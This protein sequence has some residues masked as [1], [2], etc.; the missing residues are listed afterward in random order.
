MP[1]IVPPKKEKEVRKKPHATVP[2]STSPTKRQVKRQT[3][4]K[5]TPDLIVDAVHYAEENPLDYDK[6]PGEVPDT[7]LDK[8]KK[9]IEEQKCIWKKRRVDS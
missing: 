1:K 5:D 8:K 4:N 2:Q 3:T 7:I 6:I 9:F